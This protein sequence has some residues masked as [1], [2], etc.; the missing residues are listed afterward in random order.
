MTDDIPPSG[1][2]VTERAASSY[3]T[4]GILGSHA[5]WVA[6]LNRVGR[7]AMRAGLG[8]VMVLFSLGIGS[9]LVVA[10]WRA[11]LT[12]QPVPDLTG[13]LM[14]LLAPLSLQLLDL[15]TRH[16]EKVKGVA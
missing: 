3:Q 13:G 4:M 2:V 7:P 16:R 9:A 12:G 1:G 11:A 10:L 14:T 6:L 5:D 8:I 15:L